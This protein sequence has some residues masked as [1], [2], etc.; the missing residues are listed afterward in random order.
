MPPAAFNAGTGSSA[1]DGTAC[2]VSR[3][4]P[5]CL[6]GVYIHGSLDTYDKYCLISIAAVSVNYLFR[7]IKNRSGN[8]TM[9][10]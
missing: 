9:L 3:R 4:K 5:L 6:S 8:G 7:F 10:L 1:G 2:C